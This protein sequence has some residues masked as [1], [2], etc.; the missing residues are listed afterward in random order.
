[1]ANSQNLDSA[2][3]EIFINLF[4][5]V[6]LKIKIFEYFGEGKYER[7]EILVFSHRKKLK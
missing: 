7:V 4:M 5:Y 3:Y 2:Y 1:M 6:I